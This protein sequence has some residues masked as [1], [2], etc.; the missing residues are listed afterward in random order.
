MSD[1]R[2]KTRERARLRW[3]AG[4]LTEAA[5]RRQIAE[6]ETA[7]QATI[8][9]PSAHEPGTATRA[10]VTLPR[11]ELPATG[12]QQ[13]RQVRADLDATRRHGGSLESAGHQ[14]EE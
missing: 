4:E 10:A 9:T 11:V 12:W 2:A 14:V 1:D 13:D 7:E 3:E 6:L 8:N 5:Y